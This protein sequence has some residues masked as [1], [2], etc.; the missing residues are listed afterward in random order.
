M[1]KTTTSVLALMAVAVISDK[2]AQDKDMVIDSNLV[3]DD[4]KNEFSGVIASSEKASHSVL[5][6]LPAFAEHLTYTDKELVIDEDALLAYNNDST[7][8]AYP[9]T[10]GATTYQRF[11]CYSNCHS[12]CHGSRGW[13]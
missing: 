9:G 11:Q 12:A 10:V 1:K 13:R 7:G 2:V 6:N 5:N 3:M 8:A 4:L